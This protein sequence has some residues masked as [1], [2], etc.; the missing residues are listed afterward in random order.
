MIYENHIPSS[1]RSQFLSKI[2]QVA[3]KL[4]IEPDWIMMVMKSESGLNHKA[5]NLYCKNRGGSANTCAVGLIQFM[6]NTAKGL[7]TSTGALY[8]MNPVQQLDYVYKYYKPYAN[9]IKSFY[10]LYLATFYPYAMGKPKDYI[11]G[12]ERGME[13]AKLIARQNKVI[14]KDGNGVISMTDYIKYINTKIGEAGLKK[15]EVDDVTKL[16]KTVKGKWWAF[17]MI[18]VGITGTIIVIKNIKTLKK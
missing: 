10:D 9:R 3:N 15:T 4:D 14:D 5:V 13:R 12:S 18:A 7:G 16:K 11:F 8:K 6:P 1:Y 2:K 17:A